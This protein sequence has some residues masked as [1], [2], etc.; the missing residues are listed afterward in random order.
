MKVCQGHEE[1]EKNRI[2]NLCF[3]DLPS[4]TF[5]PVEAKILGDIG[6]PLEQFIAGKLNCFSE[7]MYHCLFVVGDD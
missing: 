1:E 7:N 5:Q 4:I 6:P 3:S 2:S